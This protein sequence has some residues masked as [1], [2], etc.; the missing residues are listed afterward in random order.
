MSLSLGEGIWK[1]HGPC[2]AGGGLLDFEQRLK[3]CDKKTAWDAIHSAMGLSGTDRDGASQ[4]A[5]QAVYPYVDADGTLLSEIVRYP[6]KNFKMRRPDG[7]GRWIWNLDGVRR[8]LS[9]GLRQRWQA[10]A[11][12]ASRQA[13][14]GVD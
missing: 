14:A 5:P 1:C 9:R 12:S 11:H 7:K 3:G 4:C 13:I 2:D 8:L 6:G 10:P